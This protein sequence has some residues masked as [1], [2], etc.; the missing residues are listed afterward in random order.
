MKT[1]QNNEK[2][3]NY[4]EK[5]TSNKLK[6]RKLRKFTD[7][8]APDHRGHPETT[9]IHRQTRA[10]PP[11]PPRNYENSQ[12]NPRR[13]TAA[14]PKLRKF[15]DKPA[16][17][18]RGHPETT[19]IHR[20]TR[21]GPPRPPRNYENSQTNPRRTTAATP[22][23]RK[24]TDKPAPDHRGHPETTKIHRQTRAGPPRPPRNYENSQ[25]NPRRTTAAKLRKFTDKPA[26]DHRGHPETTK[27]HRQTRAGPP[28]PPR[29]YEN[30][31]TN[32]RRTTAATP[33]LRKFTDKPAPDH[34]GHPE[35]TKIHRQTR[36]GPPRPPRN[37]EN[38]QTNPRRTT[39]AT[40]KLRK[41]TDKPAPDHRGHPET[42]KIHRQTRAGPPRPPRNY[43]NSQT[44]R[45]C[46]QETTQIATNS[47]R[48]L[49]GTSDLAPRPFTTTVRTPSVNHTVWGKT[50]LHQAPLT[51]S[52]LDT[53]DTRQL[54]QQTTFTP[55]T[56]YTRQFLQ[57][58]TQNTNIEKCK[59]KHK[60]TQRHE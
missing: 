31:Q 4:H 54:L 44:K 9:K 37:Y 13:T 8:P 60:N 34:R 36:A 21:A 19:K 7:K 12:T 2:Y 27:I 48:H 16:P 43:E 33:K 45:T 20:Q 18:H 55:A 24:F 58:R 10:G 53:G 52:T 1:S 40:P 6:S 50:L 23:Q 57:Q 39:A 28:R 26:P 41:F 15:T 3:E 47:V 42:T 22:K 32:P 17:D 38:S 35:T 56:F 25:T 5:W 59:H 14:T 46:K 30:S 49:S 51:T 11:R 29:N